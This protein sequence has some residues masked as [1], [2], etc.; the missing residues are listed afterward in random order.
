MTVYYVGYNLQ[1]GFIHN[2]LVAGPQAIPVSDLEPFRGDDF[3]FQV[4]RHYFD[5]DSGITASPVQDATFSVDGEQLAWQ[6]VRCLDDHFVDLTGFYPS[7]HYLRAWAYARVASPSAQEVT[8][9][10]TTNGPADLWLN[11]QHVHRQEHFYHQIPHSVS[12]PVTLA[13]GHNEIL[14]RVEEVAIR[15]C[16]FAM[17]LQVVG[18]SLDDASEQAAI[19]LPTLNKSVARRRTIEGVLDAAYLDRE[20]YAWDDGIVVHWPEDMQASAQV[21]ARLQTLSGRI[22]AEGQK[23]GKPGDQSWLQRPVQIPEGPYQLLLMPQPR[24]YYDWNLRVQRKVGLWS[25]RRHYTQTPYGT[26]EER[27]LE[28][29]NDAARREDGIFSEIA[30]M[31]LGQWSDVE[32][33]TILAA[34]EDINQ[35]KDGSDFSLIGLLGMMHR[36]G[37]D[38]SF[39]EALKEPLEEC[40]LNFKYWMDEPGSDA[41]CYWSENHQILFH[42]CEILAGQLYPDR[43]FANVGQTGQWHREQGERMAISWLRKRGTGGFHE[44]DSNCTFQ[45]VLVALAHLADLAEN[46]QVWE[47]AAVLMDKMFFTMAINSF[48][49]VFGSTHGRTC[50]L[51]IKGGWLEPT[52]GISRLMWGKGVFNHH[53]RGTVS[54]ACAEEYELPSIIE[55]IAADS[56]A[57]MWNRERHSGELE[58]GIDLAV[59]SWEVNKV[60]YKTPDYMLCSAQDYRPGERGVQEHIW[61]ATLGPHA[62]VFVTHPPC[63]SE[64]GSHRPNFWHGNVLLPRVAQWKDVLIAIHKLPENDWLGFT[65]AYF[66]LYAFDEHALLDGADGRGWAFARKENG[67]LALTAAQGLELIT[68]GDNAYR[69]LRSYGQHNVWLCHMGRAALDGSF[70]E[71]Q[72]QVLAMDTAFDRL[73]ARCMTLRG[74]SLAFG[75]EGPLSVDGQEQPI[76]GFKHYENP[77]CDADWPASQLDIGS[78]G[79][80]LRLE[81]GA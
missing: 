10:L 64:D 16:P 11:G 38:P 21:V 19:L 61:Q 60:T 32:T 63:A 44:W 40:V 43:I 12:F 15:E 26:Y 23:V 78:R 69:E 6:Y 28:V 76:T 22:Y 14:V 75:W 25:L 29:L 8:F 74:E 36:Y 37:E 45:D 52:A 67:Y 41:M 13:E 42:A 20:V 53:I 56:P 66:P 47:L 59:G 31:T 34:V 9:A 73:A 17:A 62:V 58:E 81:F 27:R 57:E 24:E 68:Q 1:S 77:Y 2:W 18:L 50:S 48:R 71:F 39:P 30:K 33:E 51:M 7:C 4:A 80:V 79:Q 5:P 46:P 35:R 54:L 70:S 55:D 72:E 3:K 49:G 65:H